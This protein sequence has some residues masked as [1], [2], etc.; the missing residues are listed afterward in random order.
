VNGYQ[1]FLILISIDRRSINP[2]HR[3]HQWLMKMMTLAANKIPTSTRMIWIP[4]PP[5]TL[6]QK[7]KQ[8]SFKKALKFQPFPQACCYLGGA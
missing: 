6:R 1:V 8:V 3:S 4:D 7:R 2:I 5:E